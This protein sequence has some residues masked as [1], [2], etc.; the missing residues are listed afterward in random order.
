MKKK[1]KVVILGGGVAGMSAAH[2]LAER[3]FDVA[4]YEARNLPG[5]KARSIPVKGSGENG[6]KELP[7]GYDPTFKNIPV[8]SLSENNNLRQILRL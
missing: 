8:L 4:V 6:K 3:G 7:G 5:G 2:E 1:K